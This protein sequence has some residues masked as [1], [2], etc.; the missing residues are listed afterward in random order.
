MYSACQLFLVAKKLHNARLLI[1]FEIENNLLKLF[2]AMVQI[3]FTLS[4]LVG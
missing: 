1:L 3:D 4:T 2:E